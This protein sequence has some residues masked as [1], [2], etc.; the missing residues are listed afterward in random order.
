ME[1]TVGTTPTEIVSTPTES[2]STPT[3]IKT[4]M[5]TAT[6]IYNVPPHLLGRNMDNPLEDMI[7]S[8]RRIQK[9]RLGVRVP[10]RNLTSQ[11]VSQDEIAQE[12]YER[13][14]RRGTVHDRP[15]GGDVFFTKKLTHRLAKRITPATN[16]PELSPGILGDKPQLPT[17]TDKCQLPVVEAKPADPAPMVSALRYKL[18]P[19]K[20]REIALKQLMELPTSKRKKRNVFEIKPKQQRQSNGVSPNQQVNKTPSTNQKS[21]MTPTTPNS[22]ITSVHNINNNITEIQQIQEITPPPPEETIEIAGAII[23]V[24]RNFKSPRRTYSLRK[25]LHINHDV[26]SEV[27]ITRAKSVPKEKSKDKSKKTPK[28][29]T[30]EMPKEKS[31]ETQKDKNRETSTKDKKEKDPTPTKA[32]REIANLLGDEGA[33]KLLYDVET[34][35]SQN[36]KKRRFRTVDGKLKDLVL[37]T[38]LVKNAVMRL[39]STPKRS[40]RRS[41]AP[42]VPLNYSD[43]KRRRSRDSPQPVLASI[44]PPASPPE[45]AFRL[46]ASRIIR[47]HSSS[48][49]FSS[50]SGSPTVTKRSTIH[51]ANV[52]D[53]EKGSAQYDQL[54]GNGTKTETKVFLFFKF[55]Y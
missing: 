38:R 46:G 25:G 39:S 37:K 28:E 32:S 35:A 11:I 14:A 41:A 43:I 54:V 9:P 27:D 1:T 18:D 13:S 6:R 15:E 30:K 31:K 4:E 51:G 2:G 10:C 22:G 52:T 23:P 48:S 33:I 20:E 7:G 24:T 42:A 40:P 29:K 50:R 5:A 45:F 44:S 17:N 8:G 53:S 34:G 47:R 16:L 49:S 36:T 55:I 21:V 26:E 3:E 12:I 19:E